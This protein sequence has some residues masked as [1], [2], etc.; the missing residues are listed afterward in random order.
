MTLRF[1]YTLRNDIMQKDPLTFIFN[2]I[3]TRIKSLLNKCT[4]RQNEPSQS[5]DDEEQRIWFTIPYVSNIAEK[6]RNIT[7]DL[8]VNLS[9]FSLN[10]MRN[11]IRA[12][13]D[14][15]PIQS[16]KN[17]V[18][19]ISCKNCDASYVGQTMRQLKTRMSEHRNHI[20]RNTTTQ[21]VITE[22]R[23][24]LDHEFDW[25]NV[26]I[27]DREPYLSKRLV[28]EMAHIKL[29]KNSLNSQTD[30]DFLHHAYVS[31]LNKL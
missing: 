4:R 27:L 19:K 21:S 12:Q 2:T 5:N 29:Q 26:Q 15:L 9:F 1:R 13:K 22:H 30:T 23:I 7:K 14:I 16:N 18:Y 6:F 8:N 17:V 28:S 20:H 25:E 11:F 31:I 10:K 24:N 3:N